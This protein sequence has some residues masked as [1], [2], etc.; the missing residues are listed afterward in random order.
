MQQLGSGVN[1]KEYPSRKHFHNAKCQIKCKIVK[2]IAQRPL[3]KL[4][5][6]K[7]ILK[8]K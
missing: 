3:I 1:L 2:A 4:N 6:S 7:K 8:V 5:K